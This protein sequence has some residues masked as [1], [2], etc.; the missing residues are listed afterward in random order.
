MR[1]RVLIGRG[2]E[3]DVRI[4]SVFVSRYHALIVTDDGQDLMLDL[5]STNGLLVNSRRIVRRAL[6]DRD[7]IQV[8]PARVIYL[9]QLA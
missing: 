3:A 6:K 1:D 2:E 7:L 5:G 9:N 4:D 8:G